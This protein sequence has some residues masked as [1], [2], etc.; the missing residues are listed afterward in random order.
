MKR[1]LILTV[2]SFLVLAHLGL[3]QVPQTF[4]YQGVLRDPG[5]KEIVPDG[6]YYVTFS[7]YDAVGETTP[8][9]TS[10]SK[11][12]S[13]T[14]GVFSV[15][16][17]Q[18]TSLPESFPSPAWLGIKVKPDTDEMPRIELTAVPYS[19]NARV[20]TGVDNFF[21]GTGRVGIGTP[22]PQSELH[23]ARGDWILGSSS[24]LPGLGESAWLTSGAGILYDAGGADWAHHFSA[25]GGGDIARFGTSTGVGLAPDTK[26]VITNT[27][28]VG[29]GI[30]TPAFKLD[31]AGDA[32]IGGAITIPATTRYFSIPAAAFQGGGN[33]PY[34]ADED[35]GSMPYNI[36]APVHL[37]HG[38]TI[39]EFLARVYDGHSTEDITVSLKYAGAFANAYTDI[40]MITSNWDYGD[41][42]LES[43]TLDHTVDNVNNVYAVTASWMSPMAPDYAE[44]KF[45]NVRI[46]YTVTNPLP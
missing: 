42:S 25:Y 13:V 29:I 8:A 46:T 34:I 7:I 4:S 21:P 27:G 31:V 10:G 1:S 2:L 22:N 9:W 17:G 39:K 12:V 15:I 40:F 24:A 23:V 44:I 18:D 6:D 37:P 43:T 11:G 5:T 38:A 16:L 32:N 30:T 36:S 14:D 20:V 35:M 28:D 19:L 26:V 3:A 41:G 45:R 33:V